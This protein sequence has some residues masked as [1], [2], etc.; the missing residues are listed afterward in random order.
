MHHVILKWRSCYLVIM[1]VGKKVHSWLFAKRVGHVVSYWNEE[2]TWLAYLQ[3][4]RVTYVSFRKKKKR[5]VR[6]FL[7]SM[8][9]ICSGGVP[10][11]HVEVM[12][13]ARW[14]KMPTGLFWL[15]NSNSDLGRR[16]IDF[17]FEPSSKN[18]FTLQQEKPCILNFNSQTES[19]V[20]TKPL[21]Q[22]N[23][24]KATARLPTFDMEKVSYVRQRHILEAMH[25]R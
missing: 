1:K 5:E 23:P 14:R 22:K 15:R 12:C 17:R 7:K 11:M 16:F 19:A 21:S 9:C 2:G 24:N 3:S 20:R 13:L 6:A 8:E 25:R 4:N 10:E 18:E